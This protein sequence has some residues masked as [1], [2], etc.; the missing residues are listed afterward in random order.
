MWK[1][2]WSAVKLLFS[3]TLLA[4]FY[5]ISLNSV[6][7]HIKLNFRICI[8]FPFFFFIFPQS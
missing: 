6:S 4:F 3:T 2:K 1:I 5:H 8:F 7:L